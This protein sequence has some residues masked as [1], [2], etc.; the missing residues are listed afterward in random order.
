MFDR[1]MDS[2]VIS[3]LHHS[4]LSNLVQ[5]LMQTKPFKTVMCTIIYLNRLRE[6]YSTLGFTTINMVKCFG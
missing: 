5:Y 2:I 1:S 6:K 3:S 4:T